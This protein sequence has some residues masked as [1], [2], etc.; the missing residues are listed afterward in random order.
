MPFPYYYDTH[1]YFSP[2]VWWME[3]GER[4]DIISRRSGGKKENRKCLRV[5]S[6]GVYGG[7]Y[8]QL[9]TISI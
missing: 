1:S 2:S 6:Q 9:S 3:K 4:E 5:V 8:F 7:V